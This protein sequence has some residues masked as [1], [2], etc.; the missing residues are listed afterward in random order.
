VSYD[1]GVASEREKSWDERIL[2]RID[3]GVDAS[4]IEENLKLTPTER[5][6]KMCRVLAFVNDVKRANRDRLP[7][8]R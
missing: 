5:L 6:E 3:A 2:E 7:P 4:I 1:H 8:S